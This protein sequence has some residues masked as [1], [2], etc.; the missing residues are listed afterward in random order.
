MVETAQIS[1][2]A[3]GPGCGSRRGVLRGDGD[4][5]IGGSRASIN[6]QEFQKQRGPWPLS[7]CNGKRMS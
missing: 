1:S 7:L 5:L 3:N 6:G 2:D 4:V